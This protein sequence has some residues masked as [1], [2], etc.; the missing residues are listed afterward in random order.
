MYITLG[1]GITIETLF[2]GDSLVYGLLSL[3]VIVEFCVVTTCV[4]A[5]LSL[6]IP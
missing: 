1:L 6:L 4:G 2:R 3:T 5:P